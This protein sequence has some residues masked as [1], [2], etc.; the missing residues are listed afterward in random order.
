MG[1]LSPDNDKCYEENKETGMAGQPGVGVGQAVTL[2]GQPEGG[3]GKPWRLAEPQLCHKGQY[4]ILGTD[5]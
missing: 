5:L 4:F 2:G 3:P 1:G